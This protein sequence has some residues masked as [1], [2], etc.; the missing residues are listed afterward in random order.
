LEILVGVI[1]GMLLVPVALLVWLWIQIVPV[2]IVSLDIGLCF[3][4]FFVALGIGV[5]LSDLAFRD[6]C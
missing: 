3:I 1:V 5:R 4:V 2:G 6:R